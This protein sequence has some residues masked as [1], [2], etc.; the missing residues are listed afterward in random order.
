M[1]KQGWLKKAAGEISKLRQGI[2]G[3]FGTILTGRWDVP[4]VLN[5]TRVD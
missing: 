5:S 4:Y 3:R 1:A 2:F